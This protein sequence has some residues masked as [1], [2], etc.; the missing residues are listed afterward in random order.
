M[1]KISTLLGANRL[2][3]LRLYT[4]LTNC[5]SGSIIEVGV[6]KGGSAICLARQKNV[7]KKLFCFDTFEG[8][9]KTNPEF[10]NYHK[11]KDFHDTDYLFIK[12]T[13]EKHSQTFV[14]KGKFPEINSE[15]VSDEK[16][17]LAHID[18]DIYQSY[19]DCINFIYPRMEVG[20]IMVFDDY[21]EKT[22][23]GAKK[24]VDEFVKQNNESLIW[25]VGPQIALIKK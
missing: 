24:A 23:L 8:M 18:V 14:Y 12:K 6:Y 11:E 3:R 10:D 20:G 22:C 25:K 1:K 4:Q 21:N 13:L 17:S 15:I 19:I 9:P 7:N 2:R 5:M 16:F